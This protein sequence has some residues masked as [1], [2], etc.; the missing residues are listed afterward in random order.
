M[1]GRVFDKADDVPAPDNVANSL[2]DK[3]RPHREFEGNR[4]TNSILLDRVDPFTLGQLIALY[5]HK[6]FVQAVLWGINPF[7]QWGVEW[8]K[9]LATQ[10]LDTLENG[11]VDFD[12]CCSTLCLIARYKAHKTKL[13]TTP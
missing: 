13:K 7:D 3:Q 6:V 5:E 12:A 1:K 2:Q 11:G 9:E 4:P 8:G 10:V